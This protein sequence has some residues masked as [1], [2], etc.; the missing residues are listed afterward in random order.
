MNDQERAEHRQ[1]HRAAV[2]GGMLPSYGDTSR[3]EAL[4]VAHNLTD[5]SPYLV[6]AQQEATHWERVLAAALL[7]TN[8]ELELRIRDL[9]T[10]RDERDSARVE[11][12]RLR[13]EL[14]AAKKHIWG[15]QG[16]MKW[17][18]EQKYE[19]LR[20]AAHKVL[21]WWPVNSEN[22]P[23]WKDV[24]GDGFGADLTE[25]RRA[26]SP[27]VPAHDYSMPHYVGDDPQWFGSERRCP[28]NCP[29]A[30]P[31]NPGEGT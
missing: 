1:A 29:A 6:K 12:A 18:P 23:R 2:E 24:Y 17:V 8:E 27:D 21:A 5:S 11:V 14:A 25:L 26:L 7:A 31:A 10:T 20:A 30:V 3:E 22:N 13:E 28:P 16:G 19:A 4:T 9:N 15:L